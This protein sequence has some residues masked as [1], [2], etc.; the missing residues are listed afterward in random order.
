MMFKFSSFWTKKYIQLFEYDCTAYRQA[1]RDNI[2]SI[3]LS[4]QTRI[5][6]HLLGTYQLVR[7]WIL[8]RWMLWLRRTYSVL[9]YLGPKILKKATPGETLVTIL[10]ANTIGLAKSRRLFR[11][12]LD[13]WSTVFMIKKSCLP[14]NTVLTDMVGKKSIRTLAGKLNP[15]KRSLCVAYISLIQ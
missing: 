1:Y 4:S 15:N 9:T 11:V 2:P 6:M 12:L 7:T 14:K 10:T 8:Q 13:S 5:R 3:L